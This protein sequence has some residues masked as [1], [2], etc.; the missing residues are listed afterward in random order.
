MSIQINCI[1]NVI[2]MVCKSIHD[3]DNVLT[4]SQRCYNMKSNGCPD[5]VN[6]NLT[7]LSDL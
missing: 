4:L 1:M 6:I 2:S 5:S 7:F 3:D